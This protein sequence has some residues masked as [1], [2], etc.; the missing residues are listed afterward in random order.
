[1]VVFKRGFLLRFYYDL[2]YKKESNHFSDVSD[3]FTRIDGTGEY[4][5]TGED[6]TNSRY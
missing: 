5:I 2:F 4:V 1:L 6:I 3:P